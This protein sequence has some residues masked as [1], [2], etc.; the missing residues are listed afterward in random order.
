MTL[1]KAALAALAMAF[2]MSTTGA[3]AV[4]AAAGKPAVVKEVKKVTEVTTP[5][6]TTVKKVKKTKIKKAKRTPAEQEAFKAKS[7][8]CSAQADA[9]KLHGKPRK[10]FR[11]ACLKKAA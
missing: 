9:Q 3:M 10:A 11:K 1:S 6:G 5:D 7:K 4:E 8:E 2:A